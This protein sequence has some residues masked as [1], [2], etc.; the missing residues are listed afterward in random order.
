MSF[1]FL[2]PPCLLYT[3]LRLFDIL[4]FGGGKEGLVLKIVRNKSCG[5]YPFFL[6]F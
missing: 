5:R 4:I 1:G 2:P 3:L 6:F